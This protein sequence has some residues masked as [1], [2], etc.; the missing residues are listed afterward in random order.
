M[1]T[2]RDQLRSEARGLGAL[3]EGVLRRELP[4]SDGELAYLAGV[5]QFTDEFLG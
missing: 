2:T 1:L 3:A 4:L 5:V